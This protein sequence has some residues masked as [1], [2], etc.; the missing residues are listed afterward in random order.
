MD[1]G[2][3]A[4]RE[5]LLLLIETEF[6]SDA[7]FERALGLPPKTV[8]NW[9][10]ERSSSYMKMLPELAR[11]FSVS[12]EALLN[13]PLS[14]IASDLSDDEV[15]VLTLYRETSVLPR[16]QRE[17]LKTTLETTMRLY[18]DLQKKGTRRKKED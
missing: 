2:R 11:A 15:E 5:R 3:E 4:L 10:R 12:L 7:A 16:A 14:K 9:R 13:I 17:A 8:N 18:L 6:E 1:N